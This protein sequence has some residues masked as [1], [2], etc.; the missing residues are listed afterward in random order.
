MPSSPDI[1]WISSLGFSEDFFIAKKNGNRQLKNLSGDESFIT[2]SYVPST[3]IG[4]RD[5]ACTRPFP[6]STREKQISIHTAPV[7]ESVN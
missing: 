3:I 5:F 7:T 6:T 1:V 4:L 2:A